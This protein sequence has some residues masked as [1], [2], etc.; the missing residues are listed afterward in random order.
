MLSTLRFIL[1]LVIGLG[2]L[3][4]AVVA[5][6]DAVRRPERA[7][8]EAGK[9]T[10]KF[11]LLVLGAGLLFAV[12]GAL[13]M[14]GIVLNLAALVPAAVYW[15]DVRPELPNTGGSTRE[16]LAVRQRKVAAKLPRKVEV[17]DYYDP[18]D[19]DK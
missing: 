9:R 18:S 13:N 2:V 16:K 14:I 8:T 12:L 3:A 11:W 6:V 10:K 5:F 7:F 15:Y 17:P 4:A 1:V 19:W